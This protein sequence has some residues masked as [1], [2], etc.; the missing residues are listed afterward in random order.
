MF[1]GLIEDVGVIKNISNFKIEIE[2]KLNNI[3]KGERVV[4]LSV[5]GL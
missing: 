4:I 1:T 3:V 5:F 2:T